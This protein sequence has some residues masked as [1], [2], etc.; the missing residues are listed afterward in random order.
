[1]GSRRPILIVEGE[2][3]KRERLY[4]ALTGRGFLV[5]AARSGATALD[6][7]RH[8]WPGLIIAA[9]SLPDT[10]GWE[11]ARQI[12]AFNP[13]I[14]MVLLERGPAADAAQA[15]PLPA[16][17]QA[18]LPDDASDDHVATEAAR[19]LTE[20]TNG[21]APAPI[22]GT[23]LMVDDEPKL[24]AI[25]QEFLHLYGFLVVTA[26]S[27]EAA[28]EHLAQSLPRAVLMDVRMPGMDG[29]VTLKKIRLLRPHVPVIMVTQVSDERTMQEAFT[30]GASAY[31]TK[32]FSLDHVKST[33]LEVVGGGAG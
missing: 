31:I 19:W 8:E 15:G 5:L 9:T 12:R 24:R 1:M 6:S 33:L 30:L 22:S 13:V 27:G 18:V 4:D 28:L 26:P 3:S 32:P 25:V 21:S 20:T 16:I 23:V 14:P 2:L 10:T 17:A 11:L 29:L 7:L